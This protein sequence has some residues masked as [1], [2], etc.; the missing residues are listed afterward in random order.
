MELVD[1][2]WSTLAQIAPYL[3]LG[4]FISGLLHVLVPAGWIAKTLAG[5]GPSAVVKAALIGIP[6]PLCSCAVVPVAE[7]LRR[8]GA[9]KG[10]T[11]TFLATT[12]STGVDSAAAT[13]GMLGPVFSLIR[14]AYA[15]VSGVLL[16]WLIDAA[17]KP[18]PTPAHPAEPEIVEEASCG[19]P[20]HPHHKSKLELAK[21]VF[22][23][24]FGDIL[25]SL[26][27]WLLIGIGIGGFLSWLVPFGGLG[28]WVA[29]PIL[30]YAA[31]LLASGPLYVCAT[32]S[33][34]IAASL[35]ANGMSPGAA[36]V[37]LTVGPATNT[38]TLGFIG[39]KLGKKSL[40]IY[41]AVVILSSIG[42]GA[43]IDVVGASWHTSASIPCHTSLAWW[44]HAAAGILLVLMFRDLRLPKSKTKGATVKISIPSI[45][46]GNCVRHV[47]RALETV[48]GAQVQTVDVATKTATVGGSASKADLLAALDRD[49]YPGTL[50]EG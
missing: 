4:L 23:H 39:S 36:L 19:L 7:H 22:E 17:T 30:A 50:L 16:G 21:D 48:P 42:V 20:S 1:A 12:P 10:A 31:M 25:F 40:V 9:G 49:G 32:G 14:L 35:V 6:M 5:T 44:E 33:I 37:F 18:D 24:G 27:K 47:T 29:N 46:C 15:F 41:L 13:W 3:L 2:L 45:S 28:S 8:D 26:R 38:T 43:V 34:P 11:A